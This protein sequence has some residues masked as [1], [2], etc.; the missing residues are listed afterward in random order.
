MEKTKNLKKQLLA[1]IIMLLVAAVALGTSTYAWF[2]AQNSVSATSMKVQAKAESGIVISNA[3]NGAYGTTAATTTAAK[4]LGPTC[5]LNLT[6]W[7]HAMSTE[8][9]DAQKAQADANYTDISSENPYS[10]NN[11]YIKSAGTEL[12]LAE[13]GFLIKSIQ[14][15]TPAAQN[16]SKSLRLAVKIGTSITVFAPCRDADVTATTHTLAAL[17]SSTADTP[18]AGITSVPANDATPIHAEI[19]IWFDGEDDDCKSANIVNSLENLEL[20]VNFEAVQAS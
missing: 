16:L 11:F 18:V 15:T 1:A 17:K 7:E 5:T 12:A 20:T 13:N 19:Y 8:F 9:N 14:L 6:K 10:L 3:A 2:V 4:T